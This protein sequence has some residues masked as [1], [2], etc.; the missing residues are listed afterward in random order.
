[1]HSKAPNVKD[2]KRLNEKVFVTD[3]CI[4]TKISL[5]IKGTI[6]ES[7]GLSVVCSMAR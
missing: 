3:S 7:P 2:H 4:Y 5:D 6:R 1:M